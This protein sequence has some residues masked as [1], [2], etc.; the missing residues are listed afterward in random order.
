MWD[1]A[2]LMKKKKKKKKEKLAI[3]VSEHLNDIV[4][5]MSMLRLLISSHAWALFCAS[6]LYDTQLQVGWYSFPLVMRGY[7]E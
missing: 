5:I 2:T 1:L 4:W 6:V 3:G 7:V